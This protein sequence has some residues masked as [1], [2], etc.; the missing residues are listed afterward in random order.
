[1][2]LILWSYYG[3][4][5]NCI[6]WNGNDVVRIEE[7]FILISEFVIVTNNEVCLNNEKY[8]NFLVSLKRRDSKENIHVTDQSAN[9]NYSTILRELKKLFKEKDLKK[10]N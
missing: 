1:M 4:L 3:V 6:R 9:I 5:E 8:Q 2:K 7:H 10:E